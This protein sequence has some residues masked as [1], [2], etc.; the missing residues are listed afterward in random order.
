MMLFF[1]R[2]I[3][4]KYSIHFLAITWFIGTTLIGFIFE[5]FPSTNPLLRMN[6]VLY[7]LVASRLL[8]SLLSVLIL[9]GIFRVLKK[10]VTKVGILYL[11][12][13]VITLSLCIAS[14]TDALGYIFSG[15]CEASYWCMRT[16][17]SK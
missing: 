3:K 14:F 5:K 2:I 17:F 15:D 4:G 7:L 16:Y 6:T 9:V 11:G 12:I 1:K 8:Q 10:E 13:I